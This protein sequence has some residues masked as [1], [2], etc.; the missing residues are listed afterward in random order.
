MFIFKWIRTVKTE[1]WEKNLK[2]TAYTTSSQENIKNIFVDFFI[3]ILSYKDE[4]LPEGR[5]YEVGISKW[6]DKKINIIFDLEK[7][8]GKIRD[9]FKQFLDTFWI[10]EN[11]L[12]IKPYG[13]ELS[14]E[15]QKIV[16]NKLLQE[17]KI[18]QETKKKQ[19][20]DVSSKKVQLD[21][22]KLKELKDDI[23]D[24]VKEM[25]EFMPKAKPIAPNL[26]FDLENA[27]NDI[28]KYRK[29]TNAY[30]LAEVYK[31]AL[32]ISEKLYNK[33]YDYLKKEEINQSKDNIISEIDIVREY[34]NY[35]K[36]KR[37][38]GIEKVD[39]K[40]FWFPWYEVIYY[41][42]FWKAWVNLKLILKEFIEKYKLN[43]FKLEDILTFFQFIILFLII[44][45]SL[46]LIYKFLM[47]NGEWK[48]SIFYMLFNVAFIGFSI[49][50]WKLISKKHSLISII[51]I[52]I[53]FFVQYISIKYF[54]F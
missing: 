14:E 35:M 39:S 9:A 46:L 43:Y 30:K 45:Y 6:E 52:L 50:I 34:K 38:K 18:W 12:Y 25:Q 23:N 49:T 1:N 51:V 27:I 5:F 3:V 48:E 16:L 54:A 2:I 32:E 24:F 36:V 42:I 7:E 13:V 11:L 29:T 21:N 17:N 15:K 4:Q 41:K 26:T 20:E 33:Y 53:L 28:L 10:T 31:V 22:S 47:E 44:D 37:A 19:T 8:D 40:E